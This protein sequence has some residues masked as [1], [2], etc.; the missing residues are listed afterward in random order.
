[1]KGLITPTRLAWLVAL[2]FAIVVPHFVGGYVT[3]ILLLIAI[4]S[5]VAISLNLLYG[6]TGQL[7]LGHSAF[8][9]IG[10]YTLGI[11]AVKLHIGFWPGFF[12]AI[13]M[14]GI[15]GFLIGIPALKLRGPYFV[16]VT[17]GFAAIVGV[18][19]QGWSDFTGGANGLAGVPR[20]NPIGPIHFDSLVSMYYFVLFF[21]VLIAIVCHRVVHSL[22]GRTFIAISH[23]ERLAEALGINTMWKKLTSFVISA[24][25]SGVAGALYASY[26]SVISPDIAYFERGMDVLSLLIVGGA[27]TMA[28][29]VVGAFV[30]TAIPEGMQIVPT[31]RTLIDGVVLLLFIIFLP[32]GI[33][34]GVKGLVLRRRLS[35][36]GV[37]R[38]G[39]A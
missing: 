5:I 21:L 29:P 16:L 15:F 20:P 32:V 6:Y 22:L 38:N 17:L 24:V 30:M 8:L 19:V 34:G 35:K 18:V 26:N 13:V 23:D 25:F 28:G 3:S 14:A 36:S 33:T 1:M 27:G 31:L 39:A 11:L 2:V 37:E 7:S 10:A 4:W 12:A 9:G